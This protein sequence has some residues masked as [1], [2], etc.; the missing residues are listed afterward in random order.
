[1][2]MADSNA[3]CFLQYESLKLFFVYPYFWAYILPDINKKQ[4]TGAS[5]AQGKI[6]LTWSTIY[7]ELFEALQVILSASESAGMEDG[8]GGT[9]LYWDCQRA[10]VYEISAFSH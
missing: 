5:P 2:R 6:C 8:K 1:M 7:S 3:P 4:T 9:H 10:R